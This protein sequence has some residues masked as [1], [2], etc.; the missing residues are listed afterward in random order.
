MLLLC[1]LPPWRPQAIAHA[2]T[3]LKKHNMQTQCHFSPQRMSANTITT[4]A[5]EHLPITFTM[6]L[7]AS[8]A[9]VTIVM[10]NAAGHERPESDADIEATLKPLFSCPL[11]LDEQRSHYH[12]DTKTR[13][14]RMATNCRW[15][16]CPDRAHT[17]CTMAMPKRAEPGGYKRSSPCPDDVPLRLPCRSLSC[18]PKGPQRSPRRVD[19]AIPKLVLWTRCYASS[20]TKPTRHPSRCRSRVLA[21]PRQMFSKSA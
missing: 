5:T 6:P 1:T 8:I 17:N 12:E 18:S 10:D 21:T 9:R 19:Q 14:G 4:G 15:E 3:N 11:L 20:G 7:P 16:S 2:S 13:C